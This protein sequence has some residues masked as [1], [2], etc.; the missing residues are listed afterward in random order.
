MQD[1]PPAAGRIS[2]RIP[3]R[4]SALP[5]SVLLYGNEVS[6]RETKGA[7]ASMISKS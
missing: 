4:R 6:Y 3:L 7:V 2:G 5:R 1:P